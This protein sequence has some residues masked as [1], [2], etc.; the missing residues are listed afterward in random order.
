LNNIFSLNSTGNAL[1]KQKAANLAFAQQDPS[2][3][4]SLLEASNYYYSENEESL[5]RESR[6]YAEDYDSLV[7]QEVREFQ[8]FY[9]SW[10]DKRNQNA[11]ENVDYYLSRQWT[12][13]DRLRIIE[14]GRK[15][16]TFNMIR[17]HMQAVLGEAVGQKTEWRVLPAS[18]KAQEHADYVNKM[19]RWA[20][21]TARYQQTR[22]D[23]F[24][25][26][27]IDGV[28][29]VGTRQDPNDPLGGIEID[30]IPSR[31]FM[32]D[33]HSTK[34]SSLRGVDRL[35]RGRWE[36]RVALAYQYPE[37]K[38]ELLNHSD[39]MHEHNGL[40]SM[41]QHIRPKVRGLT[42]K[43]QLDTRL[44]G[45]AGML[46]NSLLFVREW[47]RRRPVPKWRVQDAYSEMIWDFPIERKDAAIQHVETLL[48][49]YQQ[50]EIRAQIGD[51]SPV[52]FEPRRVNAMVIDQ[53]ILVGN[54]L[55]RVNKTTSGEVPYV[56]YIPEWYD[57][58]ITS[59]FEHY[60][61]PQR[62]HNRIISFIDQMA[63]GNKGVRVLNRFG[64]PE[65]ITD[66]SLRQQLSN[67]NSVIIVNRGGNDFDVRRLLTNI[68]PPNHGQLVHALL[69]YTQNDMKEMMGG[70]N[71]IGVLQSAGQSGK[72]AE[73][74]TQAAS[75]LTANLFDAF[76][77]ADQQVGERVQYLLQH[78]HPATQMRAADE[79]GN[80]EF[81]NMVQN[82]I[83]TIKDLKYDV[84]V[85]EVVPSPTEQLMQ[86]KTL[87]NL[88]QQLGPQVGS[89]IVP[90]IIER[91]TIPYKVKQEMLEGIKSANEQAQANIEAER[92]QKQRSEDMDY[93]I[94]QRTLDLKERQVQVLENNPTKV[95]MQ[96]KMGA[97]PLT[98]ATLLE[99][100]G[101]E[102]DPL[103]IA[104]GKSLQ[105]LM[106]VEEQGLYQQAYY[107]NLPAAVMQQEKEKAMKRSPV[108]TPRDRMH[109][110]TR[111]KKK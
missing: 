25:D 106:N 102:A 49:F 12:N 68:D 81:F 108:T 16:Y 15:P 94:K 38:H 79:A 50:D 90:A 31:E 111:E 43:N 92:A 28:G 96:Y 109:R 27:L 52:I 6:R 93:E 26:G 2:L 23:V 19:M 37:W 34:D 76:R 41:Y 98:E 14:T 105:T 40:E 45:E 91:T 107:D 9:S 30:R 84:T 57:G 20:A 88:A 3:V 56:F 17:P 48:A 87:E 54:R 77:D 55:L 24:R 8:E 42:N 1:S 13:D 35:W 83:Q 18:R 110:A 67:P 33:I 101:V 53:C 75:T 82:G 10:F 85:T 97:D 58:E 44:G 72:S 60:K 47:Y 7:L 62:F 69:N 36:S 74:L 78:L 32:W 61:D 66:D 104:A 21:Q 95:T 103:F 46:S 100:A 63:N 65:S 89:M 86:Q 29:V 11:E 4:P 64:I 73:V 71:R 70:L 5:L 22:K 99:D 59:Y 80:V 39:P 51:V